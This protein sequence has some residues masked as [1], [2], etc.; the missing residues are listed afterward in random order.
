[1]QNVY[2]LLGDTP[3]VDLARPIS[4]RVQR[5]TYTA[6]RALLDIN[7]DGQY[8]FFEWTSAGRY[9][10][11]TL[12]GTMTEAT[13]RAIK[14]LYFGF[15]ME[16]LFLR[17]DLEGRARQVL[18]EFTAMRFTLLEPADAQL[19]V[20]WPPQSP[21]IAQFIQRGKPQLLA[22]DATIAVGLDK[23]LE[24]S[25]PFDLLGVK[26]GQ[27]L[28]FFVELLAGNQSRDRAPREGAIQLTR[29]GPDF[30]ARMWD[31]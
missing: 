31:V 22:A 15:S 18:A 14:E 24:V 17:V 8:T 30:E 1:L 20:T 12:R 13:P 6:P 16:T 23:I 25:I 2:T 4:K 27:P 28:Q 21:A 3:P 10:T 29:P 9:P 5:P 19:L 7:I 26:V 11:Q